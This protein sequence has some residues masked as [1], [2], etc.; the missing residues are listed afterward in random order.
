MATDPR[1][2]VRVLKSPGKA[3]LR[4]LSPME[5]SRLL[6]ALR[7][8]AYRA[9][10][11]GRWLFRAGAMSWDE[12]TNLPQDLR[13]ELATRYDVQALRI[14]QRLVSHD[15][16]RKFLFH[17]RDGEAVESVMIPMPS[18][19]T[20]CLS[21]QIGCAR[22]CQ[23][24]ATA[25]KG[26]SRSLQCGEILEQVIHLS[27]DLG[28]QP[29]SGHGD[30]QFNLVLMGMGEPLDN[31]AQVAP[32]LETLTARAGFGISVRRVTISTSG[33]VMGLKRL[34]TFGPKVGLTLSLCG[35]SPSTRS[36]LMPSL[37][38]HPLPEILDL[39]EAYARRIGRRVTLAYILL[40]GLT[41][42]LNEARL[43]AACARGRPFKINLIPWNVW[44][45]CG[46]K[47]PESTRVDRFQECLLAEGLKA[48]VRASG[49]QDIDAACGQLRRRSQSSPQ[50]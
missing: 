11:L 3:L 2:Q 12:M 20:F 40:G 43:L 39:A 8:P 32:A 33:P 50:S 17:L 6:A 37:A 13:R 21:S 26:L 48:T 42:D 15:G 41:D 23:F 18:Y 7:Q 34:L 27:N 44:E 9:R 4:D 45:G 28:N 49:G 36:R 47:A 1:P 38:S 25:R 29:V 31:W 10:Q 35:I 30:R 16:T 14:E 5:L 46:W 22:N 24:C 19:T